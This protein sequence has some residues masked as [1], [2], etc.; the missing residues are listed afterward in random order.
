[1][2]RYIFPLILGLGGVA[3]LLSLGVWQVKRLHWKEALLASI[4]A[5]IGAMPAELASVGAPD[6]A[7][8]RYL[9]VSVKGATTGQ[10]FLVITGS[11]DAGAGYE[12][13]DAFVTD[14]GRRVMLDR[15]F[16]PEADRTKPRPPADLTVTGNLD[17]PREAD[18]Y[19]P[20]PDPATGV[21]FARDVSAMA[22]F[23]KTDPLLV[24]VRTSEGGDPAI[25][26]VPVD[27]SAIP[28]DHL[29]YAITWFSLA[30]VWAGMTAYLLWRIRQRTV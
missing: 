4:N 8:Q 16:I 28:N 14:T 21:W 9:P 19:T 25:V 2:K 22:D 15:G 10:E 24:V 26:P 11:R 17:W 5:R 30:A 13:I 7:S 20:P 3:I 23:L 29:Q 6:E 27:T 1:M 18:S 12:V